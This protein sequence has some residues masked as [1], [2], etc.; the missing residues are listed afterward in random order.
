[1]KYFTRELKERYGSEDDVVASAANA[2]WEATL[3]RYERYLQSIE[4]ELPEHIRA[5]NNL[6]L[7]DA[8]IWSIARQGNKLII[9]MRKDIP[10]RDVVILTYTLTQE[11]IIDKEALPP[12]HCGSVM[13]F[14]YDEFEL[15]REG[16][17]TTYAQSIMFGNGWELSLRFS[18]VQVTLA[19]PVYPLAGTMLV[20]VSEAVGA[21]SA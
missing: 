13:D 4:S 2:E 3:E 14:Q 6:L 7:H 18:D 10:P 15:I 1:M 8:I 19:E 9:V 21:K 16:D 12:E 11:P 20:P 17:R 5:F